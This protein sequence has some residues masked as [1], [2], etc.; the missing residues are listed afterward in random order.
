[1]S[2]L[3]RYKCHL[4]L[5]FLIFLISCQSTVRFTSH[6]VG[7]GTDLKSFDISSLDDMQRVVLSKSK[8]FIGTPY[9][10]GGIGTNC[11]DCSGFVQ[12]IFQMIGLKLPR[13]AEDQYLYSK[14][15]TQEEAKPADLVFF[16]NNKKISHVGIYVGN[17]TFIHSS[18]SKG[19]MLQSL[20]D[21]YYREHFA[22]FGRV[23][24]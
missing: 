14:L 1:M 6:N 17:N 20:D 18:S 2:I 24:E 13:S 22:G 23:I 21:K 10:Y 16:R 11:F 8:E 7:L 19:V 4:A 3:I 15:V 9:C 5:V 12:Q